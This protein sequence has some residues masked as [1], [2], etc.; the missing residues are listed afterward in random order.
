MEEINN[1]CNVQSEIMFVGALY[2]SPDLYVTYGNFMRPKYDFSD[3]VVYFF[4]KCLE[5]YYLKFSQTVDET[6]LNVFMSQ[7]A[8]RMS[9]YKKYHGWKTI[10]EFMRLADSNDIK[11]Y[12]DTVKKYSLVREY[13]RNGYPVDKILAHKNFDKMTAN[14]I[15]RVIRAKADKIHTVI[16]AGEEAVELTKG[17]ADQIKRYLKKPNFGLPYPWPMYNEFFLGMREGKTHFEGFISNGGK[18]RK[19]IALAAYVTLVQ[20]KNFLLMSNE[21]DE[22]DLKNCMIVTV[23]NNK[24]YQELHGIKIKKPEREIVLGAYRDRNGEIIRRHIDENGIY[25]ESEEEYIER[26]ER[27]SDE[28]HKIVQVGE[29]IDENTKGKLLYKDTKIDWDLVMDGDKTVLFCVIVDVKRKKDKNGNQFAYLDLYTPYGIIEATIWSSQLKEYSDYI[30]KG[31]CLAILGRKR[32]E[33][34]FVEKIKTYN[35]WLEQMRKKGAKV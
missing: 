4:Y 34:F 23:I 30:K 15:Y 18:S 11:N 16:N 8:E 29:W 13:G 14:D 7:D 22:D 1:V 26:V 21:M 17:N 12:F 6:K 3:E 10:S 25:T 27:N 9:S 2:K 20:H 19:L 5:T 35:M 33:H 31:S 28:Y 24:E 32:E